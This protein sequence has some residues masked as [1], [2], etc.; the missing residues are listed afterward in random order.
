MKLFQSLKTFTLSLATTTGKKNNQ[1]KHLHQDG[2]W[3]E[4]RQ[5]M[6][7]NWEWLCDAAPICFASW[8]GEKNVYTIRMCECV[9]R[10]DFFVNGVPERKR[11]RNVETE[12]PSQHTVRRA[13]SAGW[14]E[15]FLCEDS[16][17]HYEWKVSSAE[18]AHTHTSLH[19]YPHKRVNL[20]VY[21]HV[22]THTRVR[23]VKATDDKGVEGDNRE[24]WMKET[25]HHPRLYTTTNIHSAERF[26]SL[27]CS[28]RKRRRR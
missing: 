1:T 2:T 3:W 16:E 6:N 8:N 19:E 9:F 23:Y 13:G 7:E 24:R 11:T 4:I 15:R 18:S 28:C 25:R 12:K 26:L 5:R 17:R 22:H 21:T 10:T 20:Y 27:S 14:G